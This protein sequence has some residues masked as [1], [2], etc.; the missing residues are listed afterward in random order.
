MKSKLSAALVATV[1]ILAV[2]VGAAEADT[3]YTYTGNPFTSAASPYTTNDFVSGSFDLATP[4]GNNFPLTTIS[5]ISFSFSDGVQTITNTTPG[6][7]IQF[8]QVQTDSSG[9]PD[10]W[11]IGAVAHVGTP[12]LS[13]F[14]TCSLSVTLCVEDPPLNSE[15]LG[16]LPPDPP[17]SHRRQHGHPRH[18]GCHLHLSCPRPSHRFRSPRPHLG[19]RW[20]S[21]LVATA[22]ESRLSIRRN[23]H[24]SF[25][26]S[27]RPREQV[28]GYH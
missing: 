8:F 10:F 20:S 12:A 28:Q 23:P 22:A 17:A 19:E 14:F 24:T 2:S 27:T 4:L 25:A 15:D 7:Q 6:L 5:P 21:R 1:C 11:R 9:V 13:G 16:T 26:A 3:I 18:L